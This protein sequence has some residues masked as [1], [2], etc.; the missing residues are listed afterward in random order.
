MIVYYGK[1][2]SGKSS[3]AENRAVDEAR[4]MDCPLIYLATM[5]NDGS[6]AAKSRIAHHM[7]LRQ[8]KGFAT[9][10]EPLSLSNVYDKCQGAVVLLEC[11]SNLLANR[12]YDVYGDKPM[13][14]AETDDIADTICNDIAGLATSCAKLIVVTND[15]FEKRVEDAWCDS[16]MRALGLINQKLAMEAQG[17][18]EV[19]LGLCI[20]L[21]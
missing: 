1:S 9:I 8:G 4:N 2:S 19:S 11:V 6:Q 7:S 12:Q 21:K 13:N 10:E 3:L 5:A 15:I 20:P 14:E 18:M 16:Y 17:F